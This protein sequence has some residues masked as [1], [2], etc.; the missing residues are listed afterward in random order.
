MTEEQRL[1]IG[2]ILWFCLQA[3]L[4]LGIAKLT[5][6]E[7]RSYGR[8]MITNLLSGVVMVLLYFILENIQTIG[9]MLVFVVGMILSAIIMMQIF[10]TTFWKAIKA[11]VIAWFLGLFLFAAIVILI[12]QPVV[13]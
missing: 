12:V 7:H 11:T 1:G 10:E 3:A 9:Y 4:L 6:I 13:G 2:I 8:A 5:R